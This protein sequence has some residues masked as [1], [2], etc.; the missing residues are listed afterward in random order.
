[1]HGTV[2][3]LRLVKNIWNWKTQYILEHKENLTQTIQWRFQ[4]FKVF[5]DVQ[6]TWESGVNIVPALF[7]PSAS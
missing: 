2:T 1:M 5:Q 6:A 7:C 4:G 3:V